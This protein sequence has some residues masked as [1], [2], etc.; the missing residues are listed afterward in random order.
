[1][2]KYE[3]EAAFVHDELYKCS[4]RGV[5]TWTI[6]ANKREA[7][8]L[9]ITIASGHVMGNNST[10]TGRE[11]SYSGYNKRNPFESYD[12]QLAD[13]SDPF[14]PRG[15]PGQFNGDLLIDE[16][17]HD[18]NFDRAS[19][20]MDRMST[21]NMTKRTAGRK[22][23]P[24]GHEDANSDYGSFDQEDHISGLEPKAAADQVI[25]ELDRIMEHSRRRPLGLPCDLC[26]VLY[27]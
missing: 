16:R 3:P 25:N 26:P 6:K 1:M 19:W 27:L 13:Q 9:F 23:Q 11:I 20:P 18:L 5:H 8:Y 2:R 22:G 15:Q 4:R 24:K 7:T 12:D 17:Q 10:T 14:R 21:A